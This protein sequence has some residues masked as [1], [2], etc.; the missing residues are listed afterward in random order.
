MSTI[1]HRGRRRAVAVTIALLASA[2]ASARPA[3]AEIRPQAG[4]GDPRITVARYASDQ[5]Y[6][7]RGVV[8]YQIDIEFA[9]GERFV[10]LGSGDV[11]G[12]A[13]SGVRNHLFLKPKASD[14][15]TNI[16][17][18]TNRRT[19]Q[20]AYSVA[21]APSDGAPRNAIYVLEFRYPPR[22]HEAGAVAQRL[23][24][25][26]LNGVAGSVRNDDYWYC[27]NPSL[28]PTAAWDDGVHTHL[29]FAAHAEM[30]AIFLRNDDGSESL[31][32]FSIARGVVI[33]DR[34]ARRFVLR[35]GRLTGCIVNE[36]Y[37]GG[38]T[39]LGTETLSPNVQRVTRRRH[40]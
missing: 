4:P 29:R 35:R 15:A 39:R 26:L 30:P 5:V 7:L 2:G 22:K 28:E 20:F 32:N 19:Y 27:G 12:L 6:R 38:G 9:P 13:F 24:Q 40:R 25:R 10:G 8:G 1:A 33:L 11:D 31:L 36:G 3:R 21:K 37:H 23:D 14:V 16:T 18:L 17:V 34:I